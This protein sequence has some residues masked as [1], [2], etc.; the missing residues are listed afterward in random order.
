MIIYFNTQSS[1]QQS[2][3][4]IK[5][6]FTSFHGGEG[7]PTFSPD[8]SQIAFDWTGENN[9]NRDIYFKMIGIPGSRLVN[10]TQNP[11]S[12]RNPAWSPDERLI[13][14]SSNLKGNWDIFV[15]PADGSKPRQVTYNE[16]DDNSPTWSRDGRGI[17][18]RS[19][20]SGENQIWK[21]P[22]EAGEDQAIQ[23]TKNG[24]TIAFES[25]DSKYLYF[26]KFEA[27]I[28]RMPVDGGEECLIA[29][30]TTRPDSR[31]LAGEGIY[32]FNSIWAISN[33][34]EIK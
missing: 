30:I 21:I 31:V 32:F 22:V 34:K 17:Y 10:L 33:D 20:R 24:G 7:N 23:A 27:G 4:M 8:G 14:F 19:K 2:S 1:K 13:A 12:D 16:W 3:L 18:F 15:I 29:D 5:I 9:D 28:W 26:H 25:E 11:A 6:H